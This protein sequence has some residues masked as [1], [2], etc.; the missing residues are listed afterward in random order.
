MWGDLLGAAHGISND[1][2][3]NRAVR[4]ATT[5]AGDCS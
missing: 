1:E 4:F 2:R 5:D 3:K